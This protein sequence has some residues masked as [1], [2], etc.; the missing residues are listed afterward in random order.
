MNDKPD[1]IDRATRAHTPKICSHYWHAIDK[2]PYFA[3][4]LMPA[5]WQAK[6]RA[7]I[8]LKRARLALEE[9]TASHTVDAV[10]VQAVEVAEIAEALARRDKAQAIEECYDTIAVLMRLI[11]AIEGVQPLGA[12]KPQKQGI[13]DFKSRMALNEKTK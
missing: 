10:S 9:A 11:D 3:D 1:Y 13:D 5:A 8:L 2:H 4:A 6:G 12:P 7:A